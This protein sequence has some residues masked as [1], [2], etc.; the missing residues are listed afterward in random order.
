M[1]NK[2][3]TQHVNISKLENGNVTIQVTDK[4]EYEKNLDYTWTLQNLNKNTLQTIFVNLQN[5]LQN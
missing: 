1:E 2:N 5:I 4:H 3:F